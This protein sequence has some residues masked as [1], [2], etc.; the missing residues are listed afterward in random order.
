MGRGDK[1][2]FLAD[3]WEDRQRKG[4]QCDLSVYCCL[5]PVLM[6]HRNSLLYMMHLIP[7]WPI[8][9]SSLDH[10]ES[11]SLRFM[12]DDIVITLIKSNKYIFNLLLLLCVELSIIICILD[13]FIHS[14]LCKYLPPGFYGWVKFFLWIFQSDVGC[15]NIVTTLLYGTIWNKIIIK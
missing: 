14:Y 15:C 6:I 7:L 10:H 2:E 13:N 12:I 9:W 11:Q 8:I 3:I 5:G 4:N 1:H